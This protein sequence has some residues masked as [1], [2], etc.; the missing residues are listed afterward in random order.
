[1][2]ICQN[3][4]PLSRSGKRG[5]FNCGERSALQ[6]FR[7]FGGEIFLFLL[8]PLADHHAGKAGDFH[9]GI[10]GS[11]CYSFA[12]V[13][14]K[15]LPEKRCFLQKLCNLFVGPTFDTSLGLSLFLCLANKDRLFAGY[16]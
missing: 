3:K 11:L 7:H 1:M 9:A 6:G 13:M 8:D 15:L 10:L 12:R 5:D 2:C 16:N 4:A 14:D